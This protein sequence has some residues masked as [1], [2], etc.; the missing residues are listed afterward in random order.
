MSELN[1]VCIGPEYALSFQSAT[2]REGLVFT[3]R[4]LLEI[5]I[6]KEYQC[7]EEGSR[8]DILTRGCHQVE[9]TALGSSKQMAVGLW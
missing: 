5:T 6:F 1:L 4:E 3:Y 9:L 8:G 7:S 2:I